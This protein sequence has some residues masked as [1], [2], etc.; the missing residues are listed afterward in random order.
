MFISFEGGEGSGKTTQIRAVADRLAESGHDC[1]VTKEPG[2]TVI[3][4][5]IR[6]ILLSPGTGALDPV[7]ELLLYAAD[8]NQHVREMIQPMLAAG[9]IVLCDRFLDSTRVY[10]GFARGLDKKLIDR[11]NDLVLG[12]LRPDLTFL[13]DIKPEEGLKRVWR[14]VESGGRPVDE[15]RFENERLLFH[16]K[17]RNGY[18]ELSFQEPDRFVV[19]DAA[20]SP[21]QVF[22]AIWEKIASFLTDSSA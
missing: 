7:T 14:Q 19:I 15:T 1:V 11:L 12:L 10:Q 8:R 9:K 3:G 5:K 20:G 22:N 16:Q 6:A 4:E 2:G 21:D 17:V 13:L 18:L